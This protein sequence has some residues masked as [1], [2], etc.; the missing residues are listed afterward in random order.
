MDLIEAML[1]QPF[2]Y[3]FDA[4]IYF[5][6]LPQSTNF[7]TESFAFLQCLHFFLTQQLLPNYTIFLPMQSFLQAL[8]DNSL[9]FK[10][11][12]YISKISF[13]IHSS[14]VTSI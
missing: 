8:H 7:A 2:T 13:L 9:K 1:V 14:P 11:Y 4:V 12:P 6:L 10:I 3:L 5:H